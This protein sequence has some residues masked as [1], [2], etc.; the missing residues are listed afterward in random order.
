MIR[1]GDWKL[2]YYFED[3][4]VE[5]FNLKNDIEE[6]H[7][8]M[9]KNPGKGKELLTELQNW[10]AQTKAPIPNEKNPYFKIGD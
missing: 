8:L 1:R 2:H 5:L 6:C 9:S 10:W 4:S 7:N 3:K